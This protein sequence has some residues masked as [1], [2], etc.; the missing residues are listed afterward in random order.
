MEEGNGF[1]AV[2]FLRVKATY[3]PLDYFK[4]QEF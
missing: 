4:Y 3:H 1:D 2:P